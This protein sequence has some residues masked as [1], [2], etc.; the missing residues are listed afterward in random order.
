MDRFLSI[1]VAAGLGCFAL[2]FLLSGLYPFLLNEASVPAATLDELAQDVSADF[3]DAR[4]RWPEGFRL[5]YGAEAAMGL[6][7]LMGVA[8]DDPLRAAS[9][10]AWV[11]AYRQALQDGRDTYIAEGCWH[12]HSQ[13]VRPVANEDL[14]FG[15]VSRWEQDNNEL[16]RPVM[17][18]T[19]RVGPDLTYEGGLRSNDW[20]AAHF[21]E[22]E[23]VT[24]G[25][26]MP[27][28]PW[29]FRHGYQ[30]RRRIDPELAERTGLDPAM[31]YPLPG[32]YDTQAEA[33]AALERE[34]ADLPSTLA[35]EGERLFV[36]EGKGLNGKGLSMLAYLQW[37]GTWQPESMGGGS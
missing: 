29:F 18:G 26:V 5:A 30:V 31:S 13:Y 15:P 22:P 12:C 10:D 1:V 8:D 2:A 9:E 17:W 25:T 21:W 4:E 33:E 19:R 28:Y 23:D 14:R 35:A 16:Q 37:L 36:A 6:E 11:A 20:H 3:R 34:R 24:P 27:R 32:V 7:E